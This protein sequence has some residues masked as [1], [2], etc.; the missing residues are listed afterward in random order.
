MKSQLLRRERD[1]FYVAYKRMRTSYE[2]AVEVMNDLHREISAQETEIREL[3]QARS[4]QDDQDVQ[5][6]QDDQDGQEDQDEPRQPQPYGTAIADLFGDTSSES[7]EDSD[8]PQMEDSSATD[9]AEGDE[10]D[11]EEAEDGGDEE[12]ANSDTD[13]GDD[14][15]FMWSDDDSTGY[16]SESETGD[17]DYEMPDWHTW[18][19]H[20]V[21]DDDAYDPAEDFFEDG[22]SDFPFD[23]THFSD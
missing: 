23:L 6:N 5:D 8:V 12:E 1:E 3:R 10:S 19:A 13:R 9:H 15:D 22:S 4:A 20:R 11:V 14:S 2:N 16:A 17:Q 18:L 21:E 7:S